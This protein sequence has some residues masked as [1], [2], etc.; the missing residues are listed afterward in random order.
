MAKRGRRNVEINLS[1]GETR[2][3][4]V[5]S[6]CSALLTLVAPGLRVSCSM[7]SLASPSDMSKPASG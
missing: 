3:T 4:I 2:A 1:A 7:Y 6:L 5:G